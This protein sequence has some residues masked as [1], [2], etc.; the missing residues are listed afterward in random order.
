MA[1]VPAAVARKAGDVVQTANLTPDWQY[2]TGSNA[3]FFGGQFGLRHAVQPGSLKQ[4]RLD[5]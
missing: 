3:E 2:E 5:S 1:P 4:Q